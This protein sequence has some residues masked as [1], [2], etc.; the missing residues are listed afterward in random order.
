MLEGA[1]ARAATEW[2]RT[3]ARLM[4]V[5]T[6]HAGGLRLLLKNPVNTARIRLLL[7]LY[8]DAK[9]VHIARSPYAVYPSTKKLHHSLLRFTSLETV[10]DED[11]EATVL[12][13]YDAMM[14]R[15]LEDRALVPDGNLVEVRF[16]DLERDPLRVLRKIYADLDLPGFGEAEGRFRTYAASQAGY[17]KNEFSIGADTVARLDRRWGFAFEAFGYRRRGESLAI[18]PTVAVGS[19]TPLGL[20][21]H[22]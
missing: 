10:R 16:E 18:M 4:Q 20:R 17:R 5:A 6:L 7:E 13:L 21:C 2:K 8:P 9:F 12:D 19:D 1:P 15:Y 22:A 14:R 3:Y 11:V